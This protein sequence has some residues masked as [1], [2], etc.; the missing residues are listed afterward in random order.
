[1][2]CSP[3]GSSVHGLLQARILEWVAIS[4]S[5]RSCC[6]GDQT[7]ASCSG[8][9]ILYCLRHQGCPIFLQV[10]TN[11]SEASV[12]FIGWRFPNLGHDSFSQLWPMY[13]IQVCPPGEPLLPQTESMYRIGSPSVLSSMTTCSTILA[14]G[15]S[16]D[17]GAW[18]Y[19]P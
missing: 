12:S 14:W 11:V 4:S 19:S 6:P 8:I 7:Q 1:M 13:D 9:W 17:R 3:P 10:I 16:V 2:D 18:V 15:V 5:S